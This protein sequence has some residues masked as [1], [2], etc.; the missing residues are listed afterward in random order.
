MLFYRS[1]HEMQYEI[2]M[3]PYRFLSDLILEMEMS[4]AVHSSMEVAST[5][6]MIMLTKLNVLFFCTE[7]WI[8]QS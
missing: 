4:V 6:G 5:P 3:F 2:T 1:K 7:I 8:G